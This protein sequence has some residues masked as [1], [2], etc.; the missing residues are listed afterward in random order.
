MP[1]EQ[2]SCLFGVQL[3]KNLTFKIGQ[4]E[5]FILFYS[6]PY[7]PKSFGLTPF[8]SVELDGKT[9]TRQKSYPC[10]CQISNLRD[11]NLIRGKTPQ[12][13]NHRF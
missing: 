13:T 9:S 12:I 6:M 11:N 7:S 2:T 4:A 8:N 1:V 3:K 10:P 5:N